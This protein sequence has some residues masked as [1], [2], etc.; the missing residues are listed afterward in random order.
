MRLPARL[1]LALAAGLAP[2]AVAHAQD[3]SM[4]SDWAQG[5]MLN[6]NL[7]R[8]LGTSGGRTGGPITYAVGPGI[9]TPRNP[10]P[11]SI[12][13]PTR[14]AYAAG[15]GPAGVGPAY[16]AQPPAAP[17][18]PVPGASTAY[19][20][21]PAVRDR[22]RGQFVSFIRQSSGDRAAVDIAG[23][24]QR[25]DYL[26]L[27]AAHMAPFGMRLGDVADAMA[28]Y[29]LANWMMANGVDNASAEKARAVREQ[30]R[31]TLLSK[32]A[33]AQM[34]DAQKQEMA[35]IFIYNQ[36]LQ[37]ANY[38]TAAKRGDHALMQKIGDASVARFRNEMHLDLRQLALTDQGFVARG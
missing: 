33:F 32:P 5:Q 31:F 3:F 14:R 16:R 8:N 30:V 36:V 13:L 29:W 2:T 6:D 35:E 7:Q 9:R 23:E 18:G 17:A 4:M 21:S 34:S 10:G 1:L 28:A 12:A 37:D 24:L 38:V 20:P 11:N 19:A 22:V 15:A 26:Q 27:W 25:K